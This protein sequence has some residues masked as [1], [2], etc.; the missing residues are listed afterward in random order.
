MSSVPRAMDFY[1]VKRQY[2]L[3]FSF[4]LLGSMLYPQ[5]N[6]EFKRHR[7][8]AA[9]FAGLPL[10]IEIPVNLAYILSADLRYDESENQK[11]RFLINAGVCA[12]L[13][14]KSGYG[15]TAGV[16]AEYM[17]FSYVSMNLLLNADYLGAIMGEGKKQ[18]G[19]FMLNKWALNITKSLREDSKTGYEYY[20]RISFMEGFYRNFSFHWGFNKGILRRNNPPYY[21]NGGLY[22]ALGYTFR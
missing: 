19:V 17:S 5:L 4:L 2:I 14:S 21:A 10:K 1:L 8:T 13:K 20:I 7:K 9:V 6:A 3:L 18:G 15:F 16:G 12:G 11:Q 22:Y